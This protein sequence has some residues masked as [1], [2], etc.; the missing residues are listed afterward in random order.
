MR[1]P[2][3]ALSG[4]LG[5]RGVGL[6]QL[7][8]GV[9]SRTLVPVEPLLLLKKLWN[10]IIPWFCWNLR[11]HFARAHCS[12]PLRPLPPRSVSAQELRLHLHPTMAFICGRH[13]RRRSEHS[14]K[15]R[16]YFEKLVILSK[17][18]DLLSPG[19]CQPPQLET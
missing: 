6:R 1:F 17:V 13:P 10:W 14:A 12:T 18:K 2:E 8:R 15:R 11:R 5:R 19:E 7:A 3:V 16:L 9:T 4:R